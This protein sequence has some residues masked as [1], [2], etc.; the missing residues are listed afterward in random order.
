MRAD[1]QTKQLNQAY[2]RIR[3][4]R[5]LESD[6]SRNILVVDDDESVREFMAMVLEA[7]GYTVLR[8]RHAQEAL[9]FNA[10]FS[11]T[12]DLLLSDFAMAPFENGFELAKRVRLTRPDIRVIYVSGYVEF[13]VL[14][15]EIDSSAALFLAKPF[16][17]G[18]LV[19]HV[20]KALEISCP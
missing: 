4:R 13:N 7:D 11:G 2:R 1:F 19:A 18:S 6:R 20:H 15:E 14:Q 17:P 9:R 12:I 5:K 10:E 8:A 3:P 16:S